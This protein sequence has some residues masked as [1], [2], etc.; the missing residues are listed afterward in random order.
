VK[1]VVAGLAINPNT[2]FKAYKELEHAGL[3]V[4]RTVRP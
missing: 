1:E 3:A 4:G 2:V